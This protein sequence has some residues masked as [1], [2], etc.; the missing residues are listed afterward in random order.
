MLNPEGLL[1]IG[2]KSAGTII[3]AVSQFVGK[4]GRAIT[5]LLWRSWRLNPPCVG[6]WITT[7]TGLVLRSGFHLERHDVAANVRSWAFNCRGGEVA[8]RRA[9]DPHETI[10][11][12]KISTVGKRGTPVRQSQR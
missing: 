9:V 7:V 12:Q 10:A 1:R 3:V 5:D 8:C 2:G 6:L 11:R 4:M